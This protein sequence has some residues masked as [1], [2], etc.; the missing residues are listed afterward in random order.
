[1]SDELKIAIEAA[2][3][4][5]KIALKY[6]KAGMNK[7]SISLKN[8][9]SLVTIADTETENRIKEYI[10]SNFSNAEFITEESENTTKSYKNVWIIDPI[11]GTREFSRGIDTWGI[12][13]AYAYSEEVVVGVCYFP[14]ID[15]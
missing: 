15:V 6:Y 3:E 14:A 7:L 2:R 5:A 12:L 10:S 8:D 13:I 9:K 11:D 4:G 1:M